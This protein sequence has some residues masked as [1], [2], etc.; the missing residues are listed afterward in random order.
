MLILHDQTALRSVHADR[1]AR[2]RR[3]LHAGRGLPSRRPVRRW[4]GRQL[5][6]VGARLAADPSLRRP[7]RSR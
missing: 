1:V 4:V 7:V 5:L 2:M 3:D 6:R